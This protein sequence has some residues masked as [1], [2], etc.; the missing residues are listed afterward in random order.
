MK[1]VLI[2]GATGD[3]GTHLSRELAGKYNLRL[4][5]RRPLDL[6]NFVKADPVPV[7]EPVAVPERAAGFVPVVPTH[8][9]CVAAHDIHFVLL[10]IL[11]NRFAH[12]LW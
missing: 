3:V 11:A 6:K 2:T 5:D 7:A 9:V 12:S 1:T 4:S 10:A 8:T